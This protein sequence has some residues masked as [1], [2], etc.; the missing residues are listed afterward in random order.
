MIEDRG[1]SSDFR[2]THKSEAAYQV[3]TWQ[4]VSG[5]ADGWYTLRAWVRSSGGQNEVYIALKS[6]N[7]EQRVYVPPTTPGYR[8]I[9]LPS[10]N[11]SQPASAPSAYTRTAML[12]PGPVLMTLNWFLVNQ[13]LSI[14][15]ADISSLHKSEDMGGVYKYSDG[16]AG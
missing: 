12:I 6:G 1:H 9:A 7:E 5:L 2:L 11:R 3:E 13:V 15:G 4:T 16:T 10:Q 8:W 14:L